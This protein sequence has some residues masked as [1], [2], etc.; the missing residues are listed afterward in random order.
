[1]DNRRLDTAGVLASGI[2]GIDA[3]KS[4]CPDSAALT[5]VYDCEWTVD[6]LRTGLQAGGLSGAM[7]YGCWTIWKTEAG[8][9]GELFQYRA[10]T[11][12]FVDAS[13]DAALEKAEEWA[14][15]CQG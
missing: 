3:P 14:E 9:S 10:V 6:E 1:M 11:D 2:L 7:Y 13:L 5:D 8:Y 4:K 15:N 12:S